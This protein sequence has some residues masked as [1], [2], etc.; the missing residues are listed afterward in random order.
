MI[1]EKRREVTKLSNTGET[2]GDCATLRL[3][4]GGLEPDLIGEKICMS[5]LPPL[6]ATIIKRKMAF[7]ACF[8][9][10]MRALEIVP[11]AK[12]CLGFWHGA[13]P[14][15]HAWIRIADLYHDPSYETLLG[16]RGI[17]S[18]V[19]YPVAELSYEDVCEIDSALQI[20]GQHHI[21]VNDY[22]RWRSGEGY[23]MAA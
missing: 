18:H 23:R 8:Q 19:Y 20:N 9:N 17:E 13:F 16:P 11:T 6:L 22:L 15:E 2:S 12:Y 21:G 3:S 14:I 5:P 10:A 4:I 7:Q 1:I